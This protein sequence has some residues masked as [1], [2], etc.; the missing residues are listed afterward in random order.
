[1]KS[2]PEQLSKSLLTWYQQNKRTLP[3][4]KNR[5]PYFIWISETMLQQTTVTAVIPFFEK[6]I[7]AFPNVHEL[8]RAPIEKVYEYWAGLGYYSRARNLHKAA[9][10]ISQNEFPQR[11]EQLIELPGFGPYTSRAVASIAFGQKVGVLD[12][13]VIRILCRVH[14]IE[15]TWWTTVHR[16]E[17]Q[18]LAD[19]MAKHAEPSEINQAMMELGATVCTPQKT[20]CV[21][22]PWKQNCLALKNNK[23]K[24]L[25]LKKPK[26]TMEIWQ[27]KTSLITNGDQILLVK[28]KYAPFLKN[29]FIFPGDAQ[30]KD[31]KP[32]TYDL[33]HSI[34][35][36]SIYIDIEVKSSKEVSLKAIEK[37]CGEIKWIAIKDVKKISPF[38]LLEKV[39]QKKPMASMI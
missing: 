5:N 25:P 35:H 11:F 16:N 33:K 14:G 27:W 23:V 10:W 8:A 37:Q 38:S 26:K 4:R 34:T 24:D 30:L 19:Q 15:S 18:S 39:L 7:E 36:H 28:N 21:L 31:Q 3:W 29:Q 1:M 2:K 22:C 13:N 17:L 9:Q 32:Q 20:M 6:F 12:G